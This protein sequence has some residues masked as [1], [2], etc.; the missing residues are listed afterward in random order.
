MKSGK[1]AEPSVSPWIIN[2]ALIGGGFGLCSGLY[3]AL[4]VHLTEAA[5]L[6]FII[7]LFSGYGK[8]YGTH[9]FLH[10]VPEATPLTPVMLLFGVV[11][12]MLG[13]AAGAVTGAGAG[14]FARKLSR[15]ERPDAVENSSSLEP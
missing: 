2:G 1:E 11:G 15:P 14:F 4:A 6:E 12:T 9:D 10:P 8:S 13:S 5:F 7:P 3:L